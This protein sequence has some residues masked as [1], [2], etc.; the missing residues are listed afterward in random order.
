MHPWFDGAKPASLPPAARLVQ[1][2]D[3]SGVRP[4][5]W[6]GTPGPASNQNNREQRA[7]A[8]ACRPLRDPEGLAE[9]LADWADEAR[10]SGRMDRADALLLLAWKAYDAPRIGSPHPSL[11][12]PIPRAPKR[13]TLVLL[14]AS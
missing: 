2:N 9:R 4:T 3:W 8:G 13:P 12:T 10:R 7:A 14:L 1:A 5:T 11:P 6:D